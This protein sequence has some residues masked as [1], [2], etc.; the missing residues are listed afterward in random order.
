MVIE[1][2]GGAIRRGHYKLAAKYVAEAERL[3][4]F[5]FNYLH[6]EVGQAVSCFILEG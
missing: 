3:G 4:G 1:N 5:G 6:K 2:A